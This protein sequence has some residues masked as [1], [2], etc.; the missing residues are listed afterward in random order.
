MKTPE[1][2]IKVMMETGI[3]YEEAKE[4]WA[5]KNWEEATEVI[6]FFDRYTE[7]IRD[8]AN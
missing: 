3:S 4:S 7:T 5:V 2:V 6:D 8:I 1:Q